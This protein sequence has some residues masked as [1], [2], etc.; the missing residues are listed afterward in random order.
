MRGPFVAAVG[1]TGYIA[2]RKDV[3]EADIVL[4]SLA[5][6]ARPASHSPV[7]GGK[8]MPGRWLLLPSEPEAHEMPMASSER[9]LLEA[10]IAA[11]R[12]A[13][14]DDA[15]FKIA[16]QRGRAMNTAQAA[17]LVLGKSPDG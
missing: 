2:L 4:S 3:S 16:W 12:V 14:G 15:L 13:L 17:S 7:S 5:P 11:L 10:K 6:I 8:R 9:R 1:V